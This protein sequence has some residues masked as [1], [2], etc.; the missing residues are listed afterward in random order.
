MFRICPEGDT[1]A[2]R[3][4][5]GVMEIKFCAHRHVLGINHLDDHFAVGPVQARDG[6]LALYVT[7]IIGQILPAI[8][9][10]LQDILVLDDEFH[11]IG[12]ARFDACRRA[13]GVQYEGVV[14]GNALEN[15]PCVTEAT[16]CHLVAVRRIFGT[17]LKDK[18][19]FTAQFFGIK[20][21]GYDL[22]LD[23]VE[24]LIAEHDRTGAVSSG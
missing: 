10:A 22:R 14:I 15:R 11:V 13:V 7:V 12:T 24:P 9:P 19:F 1:L 23:G 3:F 21:H 8:D 20:L 5:F 4:E 2:L 16:Q 17:E 18:S 6:I